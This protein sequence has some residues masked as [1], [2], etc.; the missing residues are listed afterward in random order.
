LVGYRNELEQKVNERTLKLNKALEKEKELNE[1]KSK[2]V[3]TASHEFRT[4]LSAINFAAG[5]IKKYWV[6]MEPMMIEK[7]LD[8]IEDQVLHMTKLLDDILIVGQADA[9]KFK[10]KPKYINLGN[11]IH[12]IIEEVYNSQKKSHEILLI[13]TE[14]FQKSDIFIDEKLGRNVFINLISNAIKFSPDAKKI[15]IELASKK[16]DIVISIIDYGIGINKSE[17]KNIFQ[18][19]ARG[20]NVDLIQG[21]GLGLSIAKEAIG[22]IGGKI[23]VNSSIGNGTSFIVQIPKKTK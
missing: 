5:S 23:S 1:L 6:K 2:F 9:G 19:F 14:G 15:H 20:H 12:E 3:S 7:K 22:L 21:T 10:N 4:P 11:F 8:K 17:L 18:P 13:D 16:K